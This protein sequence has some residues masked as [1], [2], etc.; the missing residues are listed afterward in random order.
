MVPRWWES[1]GPCVKSFLF[2]DDVA[3]NIYGTTTWILF[4][5]FIN[6]VAVTWAMEKWFREVGRGGDVVLVELLI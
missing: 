4:F 5:Y 6:G 2:N 3:R 1:D